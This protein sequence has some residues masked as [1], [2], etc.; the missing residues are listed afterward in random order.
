[1]RADHEDRIRM[2]VDHALRPLD[3]AVRLVDAEVEEADLAALVLD[4]LEVAAAA[5]RGAGAPAAPDVVLR[6]EIGEVVGQVVRAVLVVMVAHERAVRDVG[7][8]QLVHRGARERPLGRRD[9][10]IV[11]VLH[12][13]A[14]M[15]DIADVQRRRVVDDPLRL[16]AEDAARAARVGHRREAAVG[17]AV[18]AV[19]LRVGQRHEAERG[20]GG[21]RGGERRRSDQREPKGRRHQGFSSAA[22]RAGVEGAPRLDPAGPGRRRPRDTALSPRRRDHDDATVS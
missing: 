12:D 13:V 4:E 10:G 7:V 18:V 21:A 3:L 9:G 22:P 14:Q 16:V 5:R 11:A 15:T 17:K 20:G 2:R 8:A 19:D 1:M 6:A